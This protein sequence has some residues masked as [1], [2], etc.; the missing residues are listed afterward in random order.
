MRREVGKKRMVLKHKTGTYMGPP[1]H[2]FLWAQ[3]TSEK[4]YLRTGK[5]EGV[6]EW[7][8]EGRGT[9]RSKSNESNKNGTNT[10]QHNNSQNTKWLL[11]DF[12]FFLGL[13]AVNQIAAHV[14]DDKRTSLK[15][16]KN[17]TCVI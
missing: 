2:S 17:K 11:N 1:C 6:V 4:M 14:N 9:Q 8:E 10:T 12:V 13:P 5:E 15:H 3:W 7:M 16:D